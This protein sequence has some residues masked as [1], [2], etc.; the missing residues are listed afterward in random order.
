MLKD[1]PALAK[2]MK[3]RSVVYNKTMDFIDNPP[4]DCIIHVI[5]P[6]SD[7]DVERTTKDRAK[8]DAG[9]EMGLEAGA[10]FVSVNFPTP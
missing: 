7:F 9:Y 1:K 2:A 4:E 8:L 5:A 10:E 6:S 3:N